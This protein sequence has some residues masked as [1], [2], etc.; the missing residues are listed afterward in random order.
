MAKTLETLRTFDQ[1]LDALD[2]AT[3]IKALTGHSP[4]A[5]FMWRHK[6]GKFP[7]KTFETMK[8]ELRRRGFEAPSK[9]WGQLP[10][11]E[12]A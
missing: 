1:V 3:G 10:I 9:L 2:G 4:D 6:L 5:V 11:K 8:H 12:I 7:A